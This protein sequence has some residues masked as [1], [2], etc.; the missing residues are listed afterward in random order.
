M[1]LGLPPPH[2]PRVVTG[3]RRS[4]FLA[5][6]SRTL[7]ILLAAWLLV[8]QGGVV[9]AQG[10]IHEVVEG[11]VLDG[12]VGWGVASAGDVDADGFADYRVAAPFHS[13]G[14]QEVGAIGTFS[15]RDGSP[16]LIVVG[17]PGANLGG[18]ECIGDVDHDGTSDFASNGGQPGLGVVI[19]FSGQAGTPLYTF[20]GH[21]VNDDFGD[22]MA[23]PGDVDGDGFV[24]LV[25]GAPQTVTA[26][27]N[28][29]GRVR[30]FSGFDGSVVHQLDG[31]T[32]GQSLGEGVGSFG[33]FDADGHA[34]LVVGAPGDHG[35]A[36]WAG[37]V[38]VVSGKTGTT[39]ATSYGAMAADYFGHAC[40]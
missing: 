3:P 25:V 7:S 17:T 33:D 19:V 10:P 30:V 40:D 29:A 28:H 37:A 20:S 21:H 16:I 36:T 11:D 12:H 9:R 6:E 18:V 32:G 23:G 1:D 8:G 26:G 4:L 35:F 24:D 27:G 39:L 31:A 14:G 5:V 34:D 2:L 22:A 38:R 13:V 15:G